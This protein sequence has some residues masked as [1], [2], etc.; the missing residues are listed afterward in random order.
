M[1][2][3]SEEIAAG[4]TKGTIKAA[5]EI[6]KDEIHKLVEKFKQ[7]K[8]AFIEDTKTIEEI[9][10]Q[11]Q[12]PQY[13]LYKKYI[14]DPELLLQI[15]MGFSLKR[16]E[17]DRPKYQNLKDKILKK[18][19]T[20]GLHLAEMACLE[21]LGNY[22][23]LMLKDSKNETEL[24]ERLEDVLKDTEKHVIFVKSEDNTENIIRIITARI[25]ANLPKAIIIFSRGTEPNKKT[26]E[27]ISTL[28]T[29]IQN[30][31]FKV[32]EETELKQKYIFIIKKEE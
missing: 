3:D 6:S 19:G 14:N 1:T 7:G 24:E 4:I 32:I 16:L 23:N 28:K 30:Y 22:V 15:E 9:K 12:K 18:W 25:D 20:K 8:L 31:E 21:I 17:N 13:K 5:W 11:R 29:T 2:G 26:E 10:I 27:I